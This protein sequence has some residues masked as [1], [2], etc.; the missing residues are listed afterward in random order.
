M[1][2]GK[3]AQ[4]EIDMVNGNTDNN[5]NNNYVNV[6]AQDVIEL[7]SLQPKS[8]RRPRRRSDVKKVGIYIY[9]LG[10]GFDSIRFRK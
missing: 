4:E 9:F 3:A 5:N 7:E 2:D 10:F 8:S 1:S 6:G